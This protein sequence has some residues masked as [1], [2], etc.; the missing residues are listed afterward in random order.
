MSS[1]KFKLPLKDFKRF[2]NDNKKI[3]DSSITHMTSGIFFLAKIYK[4]LKLS[5]NFVKGNLF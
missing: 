2:F 5:L 4:W 3:M 1:Y